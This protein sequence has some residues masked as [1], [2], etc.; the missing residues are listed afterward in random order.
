MSNVR[1]HFL[2]K[3]RLCQG[4]ATLDYDRGCLPFVFSIEAHNDKKTLWVA[5]HLHIIILYA[6]PLEEKVQL[7]VFLI[8]VV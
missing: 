8:Q 7:P 6:L 3:C 4:L 5:H 2:M 1:E